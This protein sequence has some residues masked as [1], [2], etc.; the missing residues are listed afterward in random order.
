MK[1][2][3]ISQDALYGEIILG[4]ELFQEFIGNVRPARHD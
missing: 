2:E 3:K 4:F 1:S